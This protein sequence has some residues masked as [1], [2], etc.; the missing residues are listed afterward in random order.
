M[1]NDNFTEF[2][3]DMEVEQY[4]E[5]EFELN[6]TRS[7]EKD[8]DRQASVQAVEDEQVIHMT[9]D[10][11]DVSFAESDE[12]EDNEIQFLHKFDGEYFTD[13]EDE[14]EKGDEEPVISHRE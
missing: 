11:G 3:E 10:A 9:V 12:E 1:E 8:E 13:E 14:D 6:Q 7:K 4:A 5:G 2:E